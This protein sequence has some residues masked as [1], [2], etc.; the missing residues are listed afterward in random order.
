MLF[1]PRPA[2]DHHDWAN[3]FLAYKAP[4]TRA[5]SRSNATAPR[6]EVVPRR[7]R[8]FGS[9]RD[10]LCESQLQRLASIAV[11]PLSV[12]FARSILSLA[13]SNRK[14]AAD[15]LALPVPA[16]LA[17]LL[18]LAGIVHALI[19]VRSVV[20]DYLGTCGR[21]LATK[22]LFRGVAVI[23]VGARRVLPFLKLSFGR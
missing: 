13:I 18:V 12:H 22:V 3:V 15:C 16:L 20:L 2:A 6:D 23:L 17:T 7:I 9:S 11:I 19:G 5:T 21:L 10:A 1:S 14:T 8:R 4:M